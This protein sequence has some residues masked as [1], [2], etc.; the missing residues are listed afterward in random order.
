[1]GHEKV[2]RLLVER[3]DVGAGSKDEDDGIC[4]EAVWNKVS[5]LDI[6]SKLSALATLRCP[7]SIFTFCPETA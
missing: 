5:Q 1:M 4:R 2:V 6:G 3:E 7:S